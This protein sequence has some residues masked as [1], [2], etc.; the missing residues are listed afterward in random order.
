MPK[1]S[2]TELLV[3]I[4]TDL[5]FWHNALQQ[6]ARKIEGGG[7]PAYVY[8]FAWKTPCF[9]GQWAL[10]GVEL[11]FVFNSMEYGA[12]WDGTDSA[13]ARTAAD[14]QN[15]RYRLAAQTVAAWTSFARSGNPS[16]PTLHWPAYD[17]KSRATMV[18]DGQS[19][20][21]GGVRS[22]VREAVLST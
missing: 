1:L 4:S 9:G 2:N 10:H 17:L 6:V 18:F 8:E 11:P 14:P 12:A 22:S 21:V 13:A 20:V 3:R 7:A 16:T 15:A 19:R 5:G